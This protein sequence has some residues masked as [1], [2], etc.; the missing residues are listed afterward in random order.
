VQVHALDGALHDFDRTGAA[1]HDAAAQRRQVEAREI[2]VVELGDEHRRHA[3]E[4]GAALGLDGLES[5]QRVETLAR[6][7]HRRA[8]RQA[9]EIADHHAE[10]VVERHRDAHPVMLGELHRLGDEEAVVQNVVM[11]QRRALRKPGRA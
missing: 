6:I 11:G 3:V 8:M 4:R 1:G 2:R 5:G 7:D 9:A 10:A